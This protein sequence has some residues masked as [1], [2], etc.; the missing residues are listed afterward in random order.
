LRAVLC[1][2]V[3]GP[4]RALQLQFHLEDEAVEALKEELLYA[5]HPV[6]DEDGRGL[7]W[8]GTAPPP[9]EPVLPAPHPPQPSGLQQA[10]PAQGSAPPVEPRT[11]D[12]ERRQ[13]TVL[14]CDLV[15]ST[16]LSGQ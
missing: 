1:Q 13:L 11:P 16:V 4:Y 8:T 14:F 15:D 10:Q 6:T 7:V 12:A 2:G 9:P 3:R 5:Q